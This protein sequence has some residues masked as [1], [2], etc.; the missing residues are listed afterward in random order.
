M[1]GLLSIK[2]KII[3]CNVGEEDLAEGN[4]YTQQVEKKYPKEKNYK[5][6]CRY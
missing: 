1:I 5:Y 2:P 6:L 3:V 4:A